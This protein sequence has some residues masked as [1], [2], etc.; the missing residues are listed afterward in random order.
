MTPELMAEAPVVHLPLRLIDLTDTSYMFRAAMRVGE[1]KKSIGAIGQQIPVIVRRIEG[2]QRFQL[3]SGFRRATAMT[4]LGMREIAAIVRD[5]LV[6]DED[7]FQVAIVENEQRQTYSDIDRALA[8]LRCD[9]AGWRG[10][11][12]ARLMGLKER[13]LRNIRSLL[14]LP[15][16]VQQA[17]DAPEDHFGATHGIVLG[18]LARKHERLDF[19]RWVRAVNGRKLSVAQMQQEVAI[20]HRR[21]GPPK[22]RSIFDE[23]VTDREAG[24]FRL[25]SVKLEV[26]ELSAEDKALLREEL[27]ELLRVLAP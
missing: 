12:V 2:S 11:D 6:T 26:E 25:R 27:E 17:I 9:Q 7:A 23:K 22:R 21:R 18:R 16:V 3:I 15:L 10:A 13:Q 8:V 19:E 1:L 5:D 4:E 20:V 14:A 24:V